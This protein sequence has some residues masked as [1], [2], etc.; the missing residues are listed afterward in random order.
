M[1]KNTNILITGSKGLLGSAIKKKLIEKNYNKI[2]SP[3]K[4]VLNLLD[5]KKSE[6]YFKKKR[7]KIIFHCANAVYGISGNFI[8]GFKV[9]SDNLLINTNILLLANKYK[10]QKFY[11]ISSSAVY[12]EKKNS[13][14]YS[15]KNFLD[16]EPHKS[17]YEYGLSK[18]IMYYQLNS[19]K[20]KEFKFKY[21][22]MNNLYGINDNFKIESSHVIPAL[23]HKFYLSKKRSSLVKILGN[24]N[25]LR[26]FMYSEDAAEAIYKTLKN[27]KKIIN[28]GSNKEVSI[29]YLVK[30]LSNIFNY[31]K[32][33]F[34]KSKY[35][36]IKKRRLNLTILK[37][38]G[39]KEKY[40]LEKGLKK[41]VEW[42]IK[43]YK[44][45][46]K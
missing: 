46:R 10:V 7:P 29:S 37:K 2:L 15:E 43:N 34:V 40:N 38:T 4:K 26:C 23:I 14:K 27:K 3:S 19:I 20:N 11:F 32:I 44:I 39:F 22:I 1:K 5:L 8:N 45:V 33:N 6:N 16:S 17:E 21:F 28:I 25:N 30:T 41:T 35:K 31:E 9:L 12:P 36:P 18:R 42:F 13:S 24:G